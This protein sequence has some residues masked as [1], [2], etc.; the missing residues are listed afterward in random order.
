MWERSA[1]WEREGSRVASCAHVCACV[2]VCVCMCVHVCVCVCVIRDIAL[3][4][5]SHPAFLSLAVEYNKQQKAEEMCTNVHAQL[6]ITHLSSS[7]M[8]TLEAN[9]L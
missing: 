2:C 9:H 7:A 3:F 6:L 8:F 1:G 4:P 5:V